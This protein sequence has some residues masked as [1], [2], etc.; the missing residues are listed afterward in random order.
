MPKRRPPDSSAAEPQRQEAHAHDHSHDHDHDHAGH[1]HP[2]SRPRVERTIRV[3]LPLLL[4]R[5]PDERDQ[6][7]DRLTE[8]LAARRGFR[9]AHLETAHD[10]AT[11][12]LHYDADQLTL[13]QV[14]REVERAGAEVTK[15]YRHESLWITGMDSPDNAQ[16][17]ERVVGKMPGIVAL[18]VNYAAERARLEYDTRVTTRRKILGEITKLGYGIGEHDAE[19]GHAHDDGHDHDHDHGDAAG[20]AHA[21]GAEGLRLSLLSGGFLLAGFL[22]QVFFLEQ[23]LAESFPVYG[24]THTLLVLAL[25]GLAYVT[26]GYDLAKHGVKA[27][28]KGSF[29]IEFLMVVAAVG[30]AILGEWPEGALL[31]FLFSLGHSLE[32]MAMEKA[33]KAIRALG[34]LTPKTAHILRDGR[35]QEVAV[36]ELL[37]G[38]VVLVR[39]GERFPIDG[40]VIE[41]VSTVDQAPITGESV[42]VLKEPGSDVFAGTINGEALLRVDVTRLAKD[43]TIARVIQMVSEAQ[44]QKGPTQRF[45]ERF[46]RVFVPSVLAAVVLVGVVPPLLA[47]FAADVPVLGAMALPWGEAFLRSMTIL[48]AA[49]PCAL[50]IS[51]PSTIL[52][53]IAQGARNGV[54]FKGGAHLESLGTIKAFAFD[55]TGTITRGRPQVTDVVSLAGADEPTVLS[56]AASLERRSMHP[57]A[58]AVV[59]EAAA[60]GAAVVDVTD[61]ASVTGRGIEAMV[62]G[63]RVRIGNTRM[64]EGTPIP[65]AVKDKVKALESQG[66]TT[67]LVRRGEEFLGVLALADRPRPEAKGVLVRLREMQVPHLV[68]LTGDNARV[69]SA[70]AAEVRLTETKADLMPEDKVTAVRALKKEHGAVAMVGDGVNDAPA[71]ANATLG[72]AM[73]AGGTDVALETADVALMADSL[74]KLPFAVS[75]SRK[76]RSIIRQNLVISLGV[77]ALLV[78]AALFGLAGI[79]VA[80]VFHEGSTLIVVANALRLLRHKG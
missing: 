9:N 7:V 31:L 49:S 64:F 14:T 3:D 77:I 58:K 45:T 21:H 72:I 12:C 16:D 24:D 55:K 40:K 68:M 33:R 26:G 71:M 53:G 70:V 34:N 76:S 18:S 78:P 27:A 46:S 8:R 38:D 41:G 74:E 62:A 32:H 25:Y 15:R 39:P 48:V 20:H 44:T 13:S 17:I 47:R 79:G 30:A 65:L 52:S 57:L 37:R 60:K 73:G 80:I 28:L 1:E 11:L 56:L 67:M 61:F 19:P 63:T 42:P 5:V 29:D 59:D 54:L 6:C 2:P 43:T 50:A 66:K 23:T 4:P 51:T 36:G 69:A 10:R 75:L 22:V 35:E